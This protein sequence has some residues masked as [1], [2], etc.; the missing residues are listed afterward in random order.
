MSLRLLQVLPVLRA[1]I[2]L[3]ATLA[4][5][6][7]F[8]AAADAAAP[9]PEPKNAKTAAPATPAGLAGGTLDARAA[10]I[11]ANAV[12]QQIKGGRVIAVEPNGRMGPVFETRALLVVEPARAENLRIGDIVAYPHPTR[13]ETVVQRVLE[14]EDGQFLAEGG[15]RL[16][17]EETRG[18]LMRV[19]VILYVRDD[20]AGN[21]LVAN[22]RPAS[23]AKD[24]ADGSVTAAQVR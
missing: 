24:T 4:G 10:A 16:G 8:V 14:V 1:S 23:R 2:A 19:V 22:D 21:L 15:A 12:C 13:T 17:S 3:G 18:R 6:W 7:N 11:V 5:L 20:A 9:A